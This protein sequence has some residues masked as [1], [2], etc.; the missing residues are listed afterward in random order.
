MSSAILPQT[1]SET[2]LVAARLLIQLAHPDDASLARALDK[3]SARVLRLAWRLDGPVLQIASFS[4][5]DTCYVTDGDVCNCPTT[6]GVCWHIAAHRLLLTLAAAGV[7]I[8]STHELAPV[9]LDDDDLP[10]SFLDT[11]DDLAFDEHGM[12]APARRAPA[13]RVIVETQ[14]PSAD[15]ARAQRLADE[16]FA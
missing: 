5:A 2:Q 4:D 6:R 14:R 8:A 9:T 10:D 11:I 7:H 3:A 16:L 15:L 1:I 12:L 13:R